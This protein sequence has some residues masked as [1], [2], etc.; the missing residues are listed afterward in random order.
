MLLE[1][2]LFGTWTPPE[3]TKTRTHRIGMSG[4]N[5]YEAPNKRIYKTQDGLKPSEYKV[6]QLMLKFCRHVSAPD[7]AE[8]V[9]MTNSHCGMTLCSLYKMKL[10]KRY[11]VRKNGTSMYM[12]CLKDDNGCN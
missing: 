5:R 10:L 2:I 6:Y 3:V 4:G 8:M 7:I 11:K 9:G 12:Y 1:N